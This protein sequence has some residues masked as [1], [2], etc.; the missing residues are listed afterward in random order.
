[1]N[2]PCGGTTTVGKCEVDSTRDCAWVMIY[3]R[4]K[5]LGELDDLSKI[6]E[7]HDWSKA[8]RPRSLEV[9]AI[10]LLQE[11]KGTKKALEALGV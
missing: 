4:L 7:P 6:Q 1:M 11:L 5:E 10:D 8:V 3:R 2:G 9:E